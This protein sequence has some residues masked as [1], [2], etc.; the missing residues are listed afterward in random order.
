MSFPSTE[1]LR[2]LS[3]I[4]SIIVISTVDHTSESFILGARIAFGA[5]QAL[6]FL[7]SFYVYTKIKAREDGETIRVPNAASF[8]S[9]PDPNDYREMTVKEYDLEQITKFIQQTAMSTLIISFFSFKLEI[10][11][12][13]I[14]S[15]ISAPITV[16]TT[17][18]IRAYLI[19]EE[20]E[21]P[22]KEE[23]NGL[24]KM[25]Q[26]YMAPSDETTE[27]EIEKKEET[28]QIEDSKESDKEEENKKKKK[29]KQNKKKDE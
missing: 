13:L 4:V 19:G 29:N 27:G 8:M 16:Y 9:K 1:N 2:F 12:P 24:M 18:I 21:R 26:Q 7:L 25:F 22:F 14:F 6:T 15:T 3:T 5:V 20:V 28:E 17:P 23:T 11:P 10:V